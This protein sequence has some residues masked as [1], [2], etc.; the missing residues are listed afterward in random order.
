MSP[1]TRSSLALVASLARPG[2]NLTGINFFS[3]ELA[4]KR[5]QLLR[6][7]VPAAARIAVLVDPA[8]ATSTESSLRGVEAAARTMGVQIQVLN[9]NTSRENDTAFESASGPMLSL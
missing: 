7:L 3:A 4:A 2:G 5:L 6:E 8:N 9:V 1:K